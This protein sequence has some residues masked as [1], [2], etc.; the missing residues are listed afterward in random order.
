MSLFTVLSVINNFV[1]T[2][3]IVLVT[4]SGQFPVVTKNFYSPES[5][6]TGITATMLARLTILTI[7]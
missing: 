7:V 3:N 1:Q 4:E 2:V 6:I 5:F